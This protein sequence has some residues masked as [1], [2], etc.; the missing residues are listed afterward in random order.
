MLLIWMSL[1]LTGL[2]WVLSECC[3]RQRTR[4]VSQT[5]LIRCRRKMGTWRCI[6]LTSRWF[7]TMKL[8]P[9]HQYLRRPLLLLA[10]KT[11]QRCLFYC[12]FRIIYKER[13]RVTCTFCLIVFGYLHR[14]ALYKAEN[15][16]E[17]SS[18]E[19]NWVIQFSFPLCIESATSCDDCCRS[20]GLDS[21]ELMTPTASC[22]QFSSNDR[23]CIDWPIHKSVPDCKEPATID[24]FVAELLRI[25][26]GHRQFNA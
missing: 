21:H 3:W 14:K 4:S 1:H 17:L 2:F 20:Q 23:H 13:A 18:A 9:H 25:V 24:S 22:R 19:L 16:T 15:W 12:M 6:L 5:L 26:A 7:W 10:V 11:S 8:I